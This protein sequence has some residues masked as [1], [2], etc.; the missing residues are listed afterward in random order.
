MTTLT[1]PSRDA[2]KEQAKRLRATLAETG[3][4]LPHAAALET[5]AK[6][7][8]F[9][10]WNTL[11]AT[12]QSQSAPVWQVGQKVSGRYLGHRFTAKIKTVSQ[13]GDSHTRLTLVFDQPVD[14]IA[15]DRFTG[16]R[17]QVSATVNAQG[18]TLEKT[19]DGQPHLILDLS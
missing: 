5:V 13:W 2:L 19:S 7:W 4:S 6:Q 17:R 3:T 10:D 15:S 16:L 12:T 1:L 8:G 9:R 14:V 11:S 18:R